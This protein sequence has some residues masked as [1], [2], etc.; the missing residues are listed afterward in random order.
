MKLTWQCAKWSSP[1]EKEQRQ[2][3]KCLHHELAWY[4]QNIAQCDIT[5]EQYSVVL[6]RALCDKAG[7]PHK[8]IIRA[9]EVN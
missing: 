2:V 8:S 5:N 3:I 9:I 4:N 1:K 7:N 6:P